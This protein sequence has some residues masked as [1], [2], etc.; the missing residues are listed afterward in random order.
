MDDTSLI[1]ISPNPT[2]FI[3]D[4]SGVFT[5]INN[6]FKA[7]LLSLNFQKTGLIQFLTKNSSD[8]PISVGCDNKI[9]SNITNIKFLGIII[10]K[11]LMWKS[12]LEMI[13]PKLSMACF[14]VRAI[15]PLVMQDTILTSILLLTF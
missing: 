8:V 4:I 10:D 9:K 1:I 7:S 15:K 13:I 5:N 6:W 3:K 12:H 2:N 14:V 11:T